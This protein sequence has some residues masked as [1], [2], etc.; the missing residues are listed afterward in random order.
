VRVKRLCSSTLVVAYGL[1]SGAFSFEAYV[2]WATER[3][4]GSEWVPSY[5]TFRKNLGK[6]AQTGDDSGRSASR[7]GWPVAAWC[8]DEICIQ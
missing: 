5:T 8:L 1:K 3:H 2:I 6:I 7:R 4:L